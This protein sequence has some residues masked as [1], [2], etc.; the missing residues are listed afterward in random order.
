MID[1]AAEKGKDVSNLQ[2]ALDAYEVAL[3]ASK[4]QY[5][6]LGDTISTHAG[7]RREWTLST[8]ASTL[9]SQRSSLIYEEPKRIDGRYFQSFARGDKSLP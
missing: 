4:P 8:C 2:V 9:H 3:L 5:D 1:K 7:F 6:T